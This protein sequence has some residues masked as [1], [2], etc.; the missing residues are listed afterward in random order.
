VRLDE[1]L[2]R[3][4]MELHQTLTTPT[5]QISLS[6]ELAPLVLEAKAAFNFGLLVNELITNTLKH[7]FRGR[8]SGH[9][10]VEL[11][12]T[13]SRFRLVVSDDGVGMP[14]AAVLQANSAS[15]G[16]KLVKTLARQLKAGLTV[17]P[18]LPTGTRVIIVQQ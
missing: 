18:N 7:A 15:L 3:L 5:Q 17:E 14:S 11:S 4:L 12:G 9:L 13:A 1:Y 8:S 10:H 2:R 16:T 6:S